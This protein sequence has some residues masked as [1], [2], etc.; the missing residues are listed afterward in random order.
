MNQNIVARVNHVVEFLET[1]FREFI[2]DVNDSGD[3][4]LAKVEDFIQKEAKGYGVAF[5]PVDAGQEARLDSI[6]DLLTRRAHEVVNKYE[7]FRAATE[8]KDA[9]ARRVAEARRIEERV[10]KLEEFAKR[11]GFIA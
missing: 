4:T 8:R 6:E 10:A 7:S 2:T 3:L 5:E 1:N 11:H 9:E